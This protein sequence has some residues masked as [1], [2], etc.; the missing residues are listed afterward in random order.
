M[1]RGSTCDDTCRP[2]RRSL[3]VLG[4]A[5][6]TLGLTYVAN[7]AVELVDLQVFPQGAQIEVLSRAIPETTSTTAVP[8]VNPGNGSTSAGSTTTVP[9]VA[10]TTVPVVATTTVPVASTTTSAASV[11]TTEP[12]TV[13]TTVS[14]SPTTTQE[15][16]LPDTSSPLALVDLGTVELRTGSSYRARLATGGLGPYQW[17]VVSG[18]LPEGLVLTGEGFYEGTVGTSGSHSA[19]VLISD[20][21]GQTATGEV[22]FLTREFRIVSARG[23]SVTVIVT[24]SSVE[25]FS[26]LQ[27]E[28]FESAQIL[29]H[30]PIVVE[31]V[32]LPK[33][34]DETSWVRCEVGIEVSCSSS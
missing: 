12:P 29:R 31:V 1:A 4:W 13:T 33:V 20:S 27:D 25:F 18:N 22:S 30:G 21:T 28:G 6:A 7:A 3:A 2:M 11:V 5:V 23:G 26:A 8:T 16:V 9:V 24:G 19:T 15:P 34:G 17:T 14:P 32:F 10:T